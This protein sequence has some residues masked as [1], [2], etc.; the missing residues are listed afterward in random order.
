MI[1][2][3]YKLPIICMFYINNLWSIQI[4]KNDYGNIRVHKKKTHIQMN[5]REIIMSSQY[6]KKTRNVFI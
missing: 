5:Q 1:I 6:A 3:N 2:I 4:N